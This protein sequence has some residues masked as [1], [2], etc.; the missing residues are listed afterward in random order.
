VDSEFAPSEEWKPLPSAEQIGPNAERTITVPNVKAMTPQA[1]QRYLEKLRKQRPEFQAY[2]QGLAENDPTGNLRDKSMYEL[3]FSDKEYHKKF[4][5]WKLANSLNSMESRNIEEKPHR[6]GGLTYSHTSQLQT[7]FT[8]SFKPGIVLQRTYQP[9][10]R[11]RISRSEESFLASFAGLSSI[12]RM[13]DA[14]GKTAL[15]DVTAEEGI[16]REQVD[17]SITNLRLKKQP[18]LLM[19]PV[20]VG[21]KRQGLKGA[22]IA[23]E[24][25]SDMKTDFRR[26]NPH[27]PGSREYI[28]VQTVFA[29]SGNDRRPPP[30]DLRRRK[31][32]VRGVQGLDGPNVIRTLRGIVR[33]GPDVDEPL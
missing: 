6:T 31:R 33:V 24:V 18:V 26:A 22:R 25:V 27:A 14:G 3:A 15:L 19:S 5:G 20:V 21:R 4:I 2:V 12:L 11:T 30:M 10:D 23:T 8:T 32:V 9:S 13:R 17:N 16:K 28:G 29:P 7:L 1:F